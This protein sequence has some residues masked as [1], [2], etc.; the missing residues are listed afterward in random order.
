[1]VSG[2]TVLAVGQETFDLSG[3]NMVGLARFEMCRDDA[4][5]AMV[6][7]K[8]EQSFLSRIG[9]ECLEDTV[10]GVPFDVVRVG[11]TVASERQGFKHAFAFEHLLISPQHEVVPDGLIE[12]GGRSA[13]DFL[14]LLVEGF[15]QL[16]VVYGVGIKDGAFNFLAEL[17]RGAGPVGSHASNAASDGL[18]A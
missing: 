15:P 12:L 9:K 10:G 4:C 6:R 17:R 13:N 14:G 2:L 1:M 18:G 11:E 8:R 16:L 5:A 7:Q 3:S